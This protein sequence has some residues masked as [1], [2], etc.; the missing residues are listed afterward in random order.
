MYTRDDAE[1]CGDG[2]EEERR[3]LEKGREMS[4]GRP[5]VSSV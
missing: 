4:D 2:G 3:E 5:V 1:R